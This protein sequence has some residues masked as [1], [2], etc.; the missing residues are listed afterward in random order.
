MLK[1]LD[2]VFTRILDSR[3]SRV[4][5]SRRARPFCHLSESKD[6]LYEQKKA[7]IRHVVEAAVAIAADYDKRA[8]AGQ[9]SVEAAQAEAKKNISAIR[10]EGGQ[11]YIFGLDLNGIMIVH[12]TKPERVGKKLIDEKDPSGRLYIQDFIAAAKAGGNTSII[13]STPRN[14]RN[15]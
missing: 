5:R 8:A 14:R 15:G 3:S 9:M 13:T 11:E 7:D 1:L 12:P 6:N 4:M 10:Y 2:R